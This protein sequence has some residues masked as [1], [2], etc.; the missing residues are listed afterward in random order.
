AGIN[1][2]MNMEQAMADVNASLGGVDT[3]V[4]EELEQ[5]FLDIGAASQYSAVEV[6]A[7]GDEIARAGFATDDITAMTQSVVDLSQA[8]GA[9]LMTSVAGITSAMQTWSPAIVDTE[10]ALTDA[11]RAADIFT[12]A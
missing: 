10:I 11:A 6:A 4:L 2:S 8:T 12:V 9:D 5:G 7:V 1:F 3:S